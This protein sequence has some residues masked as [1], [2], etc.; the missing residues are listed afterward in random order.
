MYFQNE[1]IVS[2]RESTY[3]KVVN[4]Q[5]VWVGQYRGFFINS[6]ERK[7]YFFW[8]FALLCLTCDIGLSFKSEIMFVKLLYWVGVN[9]MPRIKGLE[10]MF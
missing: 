4:K 9:E 8:G 6:I 10:H 7:P 3:I 2:R 5:L 1:H